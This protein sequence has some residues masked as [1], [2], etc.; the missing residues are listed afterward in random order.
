MDKPDEILWRWNK[1]Y[2]FTV[3]SMYKMLSDR[4]VRDIFSPK[5][6]GLKVPV[7]VKIFI[8]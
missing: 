2:K 6:W 1:R 4:G 7:K 5:I 3:K 8:C